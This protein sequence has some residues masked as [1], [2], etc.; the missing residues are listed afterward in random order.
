MLTAQAC[1]RNILAASIG[2]ALALAGT[3]AWLVHKPPT[4]DCGGEAPSSRMVHEIR[5]TKVVVRPWLGT[6]HVYGVFMVPNRYKHYKPSEVTLAVRGF[7]HAFRVFQRPDRRYPDDIPA[8]P[9]HY[10]LH[11]HVP[12]RVALWVLVNGRFGDLRRPC[13]WTLVFN[14]RS[15]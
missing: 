15:R 3:I 2:L 1:F 5:A 10:L 14:E 11:S 12:T 7:D 13:G 6:H 4:T 8:E 9:G